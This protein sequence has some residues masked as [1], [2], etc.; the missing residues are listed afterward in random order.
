MSTRFIPAR[1]DLGILEKLRNSY[2]EKG[3]RGFIHGFQKDLIQ[4]STGARYKNKKFN[5]FW[6][7]T[8]ELKKINNKHCLIATDKGT[9]GLIGGAFSETATEEKLSLI[10][11]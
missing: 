8:I 5:S 9:T 10:H 2:S 7:I 3:G 4:N 11:I 6:Q 1:N